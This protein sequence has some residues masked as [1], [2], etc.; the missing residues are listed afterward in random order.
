M[1]TLLGIATIASVIFPKPFCHKHRIYLKQNYDDIHAI[2]KALNDRVR[3]IFDKIYL[4][5]N[6]KMANT[7]IT[8]PIPTPQHHPQISQP[9]RHLPTVIGLAGLEIY[10]FVPPKAAVKTLAQSLTDIR[11]TS[12]SSPSSLGIEFAIASASV[13]MPAVSPSAML[14]FIFKTLSII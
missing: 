13:I 4:S 2:H 7:T 8:E 11:D 10:I 9:R 6:S 12:I 1:R 14:P 3:D 5:A